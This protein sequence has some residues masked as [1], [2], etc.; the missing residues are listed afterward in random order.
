MAYKTLLVLACMYSF[1]AGAQTKDSATIR[2]IYDEV[3][4]KGKC[5]QNLDYLSNKIGGRLAGSPQAQQA[6]DYTFNLIKGYGFDTVYLQEVM[7]PHWVRGAKEEA[8]ITKGNQKIRVRICALGNSI[9]TPKAGLA[10]PVIEVK[11][12]EE[13]AQL[14]KEHVNGKIV[15]F[16]RAMDCRHI[17]TGAAYGGA[18]NQRGI[19]AVEA[20]K[21]GA[22]GVIVRSM[23]LA[24]D[25]NPHTG[26]MR[27]VD[28]IPKIPACAISTVD[29]E[30]LSRLLK[31]RSAGAVGFYFKQNCEMLPDVLSY[32]VIGELRGSEKPNE[33]VI[34]GG[35]LDAWDNGDGAHDDGAGVVQ[36]IEAVRLF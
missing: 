4:T 34:A 19:G 17:S 5:Y 11:N 29:A 28:S 21:Y 22:V 8:F 27:Y 24:L 36:S 16:N 7:V 25:T 1:L 33:I 35:H 31:I 18:V 30:E 13:L 9:G 26:S 12:F 6:I 10:A 14:G 32:N 2:S 20:A 3:L 15:L 23:T